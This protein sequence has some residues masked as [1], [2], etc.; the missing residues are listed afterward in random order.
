MGFRLTGLSVTGNFVDRDT[1]VGQMENSL[2][3]P[4]AQDPRRIHVLHVL[5]GIEK[6]QLA[7]AYARKHQQRHTA[8]L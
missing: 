6:T 1:E 2:L 5:D 3:L 4:N 7:I 8:I